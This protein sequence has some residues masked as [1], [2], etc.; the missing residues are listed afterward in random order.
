MLKKLSL[1]DVSNKLEYLF[2]I[3]PFTLALWGKGRAHLSGAPNGLHFK[4]GFLVLHVNIRLG[5][6]SGSNENSWLLS[7]V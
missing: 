7:E 1:N 6:Q 5:Q 3:N 2:S 4:Y